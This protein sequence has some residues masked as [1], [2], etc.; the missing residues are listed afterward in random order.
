MNNRLYAKCV[1]ALCCLI[2]SNSIG[3]A[4]P[5]LSLIQAS[6]E[7]QLSKLQVS[8]TSDGFTGT[9]RDDQNTLSLSSKKSSK[10]KGI[11]KIQRVD[12]TTLIEITRDEE[13]FIFK[14]QGGTLKIDTQTQTLVNPTNE[15]LQALQNFVKSSDATLL[16]KCIAAL[17]KEKAEL[18]K[19]NITP[20]SFILAGMLLG[21]E[22]AAGS[23]RSEEKPLNSLIWQSVAYSPPKSVTSKPNIKTVTANSSH[24]AT[25]TGNKTAVAISQPQN[26]FGGNECNGCCGGGCWSCSGYY[27]YACLAHDNCV[28][29]LGQFDCVGLFPAAAASLI[30]AIENGGGDWGPCLRCDQPDDGSGVS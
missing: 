8:K 26:G 11:S 23:M 25:K 4:A 17:I 29:T 14:F 3:F 9:Y 13:N 24:K 18:K 21:D 20:L 5:P 6:Q 28:A 10:D 19:Q 30:S 7:N 2:Y 12:G 27:T 15:D 22:P 16:R 1:V